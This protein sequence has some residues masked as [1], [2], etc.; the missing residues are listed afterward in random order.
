MGSELISIEDYLDVLDSFSPRTWI[1]GRGLG[2]GI[3]QGAEMLSPLP[4]DYRQ[5]EDQKR[6]KAS[7]RFWHS[8]LALASLLF[9]VIIRSG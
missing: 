1:F 3:T 9:S 4:S 5:Q 7:I 8:A 6:K 2:V